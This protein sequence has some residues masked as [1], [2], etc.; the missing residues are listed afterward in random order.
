MSLPQGKN[1]TK[2]E[3]ADRL[4]VCVRTVERWISSGILR[5]VSVKWRTR[6]IHLEDVEFLE[7]GGSPD[8]LLRRNLRTD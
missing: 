2:T 8:E 6:Y 5:V 3:A 4:H 1:L 7:R